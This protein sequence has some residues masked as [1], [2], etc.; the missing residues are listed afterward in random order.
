[1]E[2]WDQAVRVM[3][4]QGVMWR[5]MNPKTDHLPIPGIL[6]LSSPGKVVPAG[7]DF[8]AEKGLFPT[9]SA[10]AYQLLMVQADRVVRESQRDRVC[11]QLKQELLSKQQ[12]ASLQAEKRR[13]VHVQLRELQARRQLYGIKTRQGF[14][15]TQAHDIATAFKEFWSDI[16][17]KPDKTVEQCREWMEQIPVPRRV[18]KAL[19]M[20]TG[21]V[22]HAVV[23]AALECMKRGSSP[24]LDGMPVEVYTALSDVFVSPMTMAVQHCL[25]SGKAPSD[26]LMSLQRNIPKGQMAD[27]RPIALQTVLWKW[28]ATTIL[29]LIE[30]ALQIAVP[31]AQKGF[32]K[33][34]QML[35]HIINAKGLWH[36]ADEGTFLSVDFAKAYD[37]VSHTFFEAGMQFLGMPEEITQLLVHSLSG[38]VQ[39]R[40]DNG[41]APGVAM[42]PD[43][44]YKTRGS[45]VPTHFCIID[46][47]SHLSI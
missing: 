39:F 10:Q 4:E 22:T 24:G 47:V 38:E 45:A 18:H 33:N 41:V 21:E 46:G 32:L 16:M 44:Q 15:C 5:R 23:Q 12:E 3:Q 7:W 26:W 34:R 14:Y 43:S 37:S 8:L 13:K 40:V 30:D 35:P 31:P 11:Q 1:M 29:V 2:W 17:R 19:P 9:T 42:M 25:Q 27:M 20:L 28:I 6:R 36:S